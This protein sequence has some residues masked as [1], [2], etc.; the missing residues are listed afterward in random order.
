MRQY[1]FSSFVGEGYLNIWAG[2]QSLALFFYLLSFPLG[3][4]N[5][6][7]LRLLNAVAALGSIYILYKTALLIW[8]WEGRTLL[9]IIGGCGIFVPYFLYTTF[10]YGDI[11]GT[12]LAIIA[13]YAEL[14]YLC[15]GEKHRWILLSAVL[16]G[17]SVLLKMNC[18]IILIAMIGA[19]VYN[20]DIK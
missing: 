2:N 13:V 16:I 3:I 4:D 7:M 10:I 8:K 6:T 5:F 11:Y 9:F 14:K 1:N 15:T 18:L 17:I 12:S 20:Y 19:L